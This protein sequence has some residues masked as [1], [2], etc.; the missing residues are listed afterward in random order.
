MPVEPDAMDVVLA[1]TQ[2]DLFWVP[3]SVERLVRPDVLALRDGSTRDLTNH[4]PRTSPD[5]DVDALVPEIAA[6]HTGPASQ[7]LVVPTGPL[8]ALERTLPAHGYRPAFAADGYTVSSDSPVR[9]GP[10]RVEVVHDLAGLR[11]NLAACEQAF[12]K[13]LP[14]TDAD[15]P[16]ELA[17]CTGPAARTVRFT[18]FV[19]DSL[20]GSANLNRF[21]ALSFGFLWAGGVAPGFRGRGVYRALLDARLRWAHGNGLDRVGLYANRDTSGPVVAG[22]GFTRHGPMAYW[23][24]T[25]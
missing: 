19:G 15:L 23:K 8:A 16:R 13:A 25:P 22:L 5:A 24:R 6:W 18:A 1:R 4:V 2:E 9:T 14:F 12:G 17:L 3:P 7:W 10:A 21:D 20:A 11:A